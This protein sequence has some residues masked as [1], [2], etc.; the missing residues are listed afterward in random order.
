MTPDSQGE[1]AARV[2]DR[3][4]P[5]GGLGLL[6]LAHDLTFTALGI[7]L[8]AAGVLASQAVAGWF[9]LSTW[10]ASHGDTDQNP[11]ISAILASTYGS[12]LDGCKDEK[13]VDRLNLRVFGTSK[14]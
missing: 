9:A 12:M 7:S 11:L 3:A 13:D 14:Y 4:D 5:L 8:D 1:L 10:R 2:S 6:R